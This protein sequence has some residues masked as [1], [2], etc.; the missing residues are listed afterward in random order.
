MHVCSSAEC[1]GGAVTR[2]EGTTIMD[3]S[4][5]YPSHRNHHCESDRK[6][7]ILQ[8]TG[9]RGTLRHMCTWQAFKL[10][11]ASSYRLTWRVGKAF[12]PFMSWHKRSECYEGVEDQ[13]SR[14]HPGALSQECN[15]LAAYSMMKLRLAH[16]ERLQEAGSCSQ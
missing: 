9:W 13:H 16:L 2:R 10:S 8:T 11:T 15:Q 14:M 6:D 12:E 4:T 5:P 1:A 3:A 7:R